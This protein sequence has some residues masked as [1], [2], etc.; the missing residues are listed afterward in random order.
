VKVAQ[1]V[2]LVVTGG[3]SSPP[4][5]VARKRTCAEAIDVISNARTAMKADRRM[6]TPRVA[7]EFVDTSL[8][9]G[10]RLHAATIEVAAARANLDTALSSEKSLR[11]LSAYS[12]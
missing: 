10:S 12:E 3:T 8:G 4:L 11:A 2:A 7:M 5:C 9:G 1:P 6:V